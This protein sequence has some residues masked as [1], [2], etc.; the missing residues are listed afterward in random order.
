MALGVVVMCGILFAELLIEGQKQGRLQWPYG[1]LVPG[2][3]IAKH[4]LPF[5]VVLATLT[6]TQS[7]NVAFFLTFAERNGRLSFDWGAG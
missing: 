2:S 6:V 5:V 3:Y 1:D 4:G 7:R